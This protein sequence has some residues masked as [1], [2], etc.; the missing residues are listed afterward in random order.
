MDIRGKS[1][2]DGKAIRA[3]L[4]LADAPF[5]LGFEEPLDDP[6]PLDACFDFKDS[7]LAIER[8]DTAESGQIEMK[9]A[10]PKLLASHGMPPAGAA[11]LQSRLA[12][13]PNRARDLMRG[14]RRL[15]FADGSSIELR[16][17]VVQPF[18]A[19]KIVAAPRER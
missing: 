17:N 10:C 5:G 18:H 14:A 9:I 19:A 8:K 3:G 7:A 2:S 16:M 11:D 4:L 1:P 12:S 6:R 13:Q 15:N